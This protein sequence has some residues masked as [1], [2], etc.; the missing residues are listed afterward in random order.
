MRYLAPTWLFG[1]SIVLGIGGCSSNS[2]TRVGEDTV[3]DAAPDTEDAPDTLPGS[4]TDSPADIVDA[5]S[6]HDQSDTG[7]STDADAEFNPSDAE[8]TTDAVDSVDC[9]TPQEGCP[10]DPIAHTVPCCLFAS[11]GLECVA[12]F[13]TWRSFRDCGCSESP[14]CAGDPLYHLCEI[15]YPPTI[16]VQE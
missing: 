6:E 16:P 2:G 4:D 7:D 10:C 14:D 12:F 8:D 9:A 13:G 1:L 15:Q 11:F 5:D 3:S